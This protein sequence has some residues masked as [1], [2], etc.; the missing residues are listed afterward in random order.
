MKFFV[1]LILTLSVGAA[2][3]QNIPD[4]GGQSQIPG[5]T[6]PPLLQKPYETVRDFFNFF[7]FADGVMDSNGAYLESAN[8]GASFGER[9]GGGAAG[10]HQFAT[11]SISL[12]YNGDYRHY[13]SNTYGSGT[14]QTLSFFYQK[15]A[16]RWQFTLGETAGDFFQGGGV[17]NTSPSPNT[18]SSSVIVQTSPIATKTE[19]AGTTLSATY[20]QSLR[21][22]Y[23][24]T[25]SYFLDRYNGPVSIGSN[26]FIGS[27]SGIYRVT[28]RTSVSASYSHSNF[29]YQRKGGNSNV[30][31]GYATIG[32][33]FASQWTVSASGGI[34]R[35]NSSGTFRI[36]II[37]S[38]TLPPAY[39]VG[40]YNDTS[41]SPYYQGTVSRFMRHNS[42]SI[43]GGESVGPGNGYYLAS[44]VQYLNGYY[45]YAL[46]RS[47]ISANGYLSR[48][49]SASSANV[50]TGKEITLGL[51]ASYAYNLIRHVGLNLRYDYIK[52]STAGN[53]N[54]PS[55][56]RISFGV[57]F[58]SKDVPLSWH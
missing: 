17:Y 20:Q 35:A 29:L 56:N 51:G 8:A 40:P 25:G 57:Y 47:N 6:A 4:T 3:A 27:F 31:A 48:L 9:L 44:K 10:Y 5:N 42:L 46:R 32:H 1:F 2:F 21:T 11:G 54:V 18:D 33:D 7:A 39:I 34:T 19:Y 16:K 28:R 58:T 45:N 24:I 22:S 23:A 12:Y 26:N 13:D 52:Y 55:D 36:P 50:A 14:D 15:L 37:I 38:P 49:A 43:S 53:L 41:L 30:D